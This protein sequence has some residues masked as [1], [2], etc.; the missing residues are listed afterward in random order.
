MREVRKLKN[1]RADELL[2][3]LILKPEEEFVAGG[4]GDEVEE[5]DE[6]FVNVGLLVGER[7]APSVAG[8]LSGWSSES[9]VSA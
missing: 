9:A 4:G 8:R 5:I 1:G 7:L 2:A 6:A 3:H